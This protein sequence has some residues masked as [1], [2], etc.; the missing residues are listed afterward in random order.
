M[1]RLLLTLALCSLAL[2]AAWT[3]AGAQIEELTPLGPLPI[4][5]SESQLDESSALWFVEMPSAPVADGG[6]LTTARQEKAAFRANAGSARIRYT[7][8]FA[9]DT[10]FNGLSISI[11]PADL[12][13]LYRL[14][15]VKAIYPVGLFW[16]DGEPASDAELASALAM[17]GA[18]VAQNTLGL[19][20]DGVRVAV[21]DTGV[22]YHHPDLGGCFGTG[23]R[24]EVGWDF[25]GDAFNADPTSPSFNPVPTPDAD[26]DD[27]NGH[28]THVAGIV[29]A[30]GTVKGVAPNV[31]FGAYRVFGCQG[32]TTGDIMIAAMERALADGMQVLN[33]SIGSAFQWPQFPTAA[34]SDRLVNQGVTVV[35]SIGN[36]GANGVYVASAPGVGKKV[37]G[38]ASFDNTH[39]SLATFTITP[40]N[41]VIGYGQAA[42]A[43]AAPLAGTSPMKRTGTATSAADA[44]SA[45]PAGFLA[46]HVALIRRGTCSFHVKSLNAQNAGAIGVVLYNNVAG[47]FSPTVAGSPAITIPVVAISDA[48]GVLINNRLA[49]GP[50]SMT[51]T[52][53]LGLFTNPTGNLISS[54]SSYGLAP[55]LSVKPDIGAPGGSIRSTYPLELGGFATLSGTS[56][57]APHTAGAVA[58][59]LE[60][61]PN[62]PSQAM[63]TILPNSADP[64]L[65]WGNPGLGFPDNVHRQGAGMLDVPGAVLAQVR[66]EPAKLA[67]GESEAGPATRTLTLENSGSSDVTFDLAHV[68]ALSTGGSTFTPGFFTSDAAAS[69]SS[70]TVTVPAFG[71]ATVDV[72]VTAPSGPVRGQYGGFIMFVPQGG[73]A[74]YRVP[75]AGFV[76]DYQSIPVLVPTPFGFPWLARISGTSFVN[77]PA[78]GTFTLVDA[79]N[80][81]QILVHLDHQVRRLR[82]EVFDAASGKAWHRALELEYVARNSTANGFF[83]FPWDGT[84]KGGNKTYVVPNGNYVIRLSV[85]K[86]LGDSG[87]PAHVETWTSPVITL[88]RP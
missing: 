39:I 3:P 1:R 82:M 23:C 58:L 2:V 44:C 18:D 33:M 6:S 11:H 68:R 46:G 26:P 22:D 17:T 51:W 56:M 87:N 60:A 29:G 61:W 20:G 84:T 57:A 59:L 41:A 9:F 69:F 4:P 13:K 67:L 50:V 72:T 74:V 80:Q 63:R 79:A 76:G 45:L 78:G 71:S 34:A 70:A 85:V 40:D 38:V 65:W 21:M 24:V 28:G 75:Y 7:E 64:R 30:N 5:D 77:Q 12:G 47:R 31:T 37:I 14:S 88:A 42:A 19:T 25:V 54:F 83:A 36:T 86:A 49:S 53:Q 62:T 8:R 55:D 43:P 32:S 27:C 73:G 15:G 35:A 52:N 66:I 48:E 81:P 10:L 16:A